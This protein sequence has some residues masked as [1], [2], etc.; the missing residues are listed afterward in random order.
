MAEVIFTDAVPV[1]SSGG[2]AAPAVYPPDSLPPVQ[3]TQPNPAKPKDSSLALGYEDFR[4]EV[5]GF[6]GWTR[7]IDNWDDAQKAELDDIVQSGVRQFYWPPSVEG[8]MV[9]WSFLSPH[10]TLSTSS[11][12]GYDLPDDFSGNLHSVI[13]H[14]TGGPLVPMN[15]GNLLSLV[16]GNSTQGAPAY[17]AVRPA[18]SD[19]SGLQKW[20]ILLY[21][22]PDGVYSLSYR[23][24]VGAQ[25]L[26]KTRP[27]PL[28]PVCHAE[29]VLESCLAVA[30]ERLNDESSL[31]RNRFKEL[32]AFSVAQDASMITEESVDNWPALA[33]TPTSLDLTY[34][35]LLR[36]VGQFLGYGW[37]SAKWTRDHNGVADDMVQAGL[38]QFYR[39]PLIEGQE[40]AHRWGFLRQNTTLSLVAGTA[41]YDLPAACS[42]RV[43]HFTYSA[44]AAEV[45]VVAVSDE[46]LRELIARNDASGPPQY[47]SFRAKASSGG[48]RQ[49]WQVLFY[50]KPNAA[51]TLS[52]EYEIVP[53]RLTYA[54]PFP[55][56]GVDHAETILASC[57]AAAEERLK[58]ESD[59]QRKRFL[60]R[61]GAS[62]QIDVA[63]APSDE[64]WPLGDPGEGSLDVSYGLLLKRVGHELG[65]GWDAGTWTVEERRRVDMVIHSGLR[66]FYT[67][68]PLPGEKHG[69][70][71]TFL[72]PVTTLATVASTYLYDLPADFAA[73]DGP[74]TFPPGATVLYRPI[75]IVNENYIRQR[76]MTDNFTRRPEVA[77]IRP[78]AHDGTQNTRYEIL[79][80]PTPDDA[81]TL[82]YRYRVNLLSLSD[83]RQF[84][85]GAQTH[86]EAILTSCLAA[87]EQMRDGK[88]GLH[89]E[90]FGVL[91]AA[92]VS[93]DR[94]GSCPER[95][96][97]PGE[98]DDPM[99]YWNYHDFQ[100]NIVTY[101]D[102]AY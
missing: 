98:M 86:A 56:G 71:W 40:A 31:H 73:M 81:Y 92:S 25:K 76:Q 38:R 16:T 11:G 28:G 72:R 95:L 101:N 66:Q 36:H 84:P 45:E 29:T 43:A 35:D 15:D 32:L 61:L 96:G 50:P 77:A 14:T 1:S 24:E 59:V 5:A 17:Y 58:P 51:F 34:G 13:N 93:A 8:K 39:P 91:L 67:P 78:K 55:L 100:D 63:K 12:Y 80:W 69:H 22:P 54:A 23:Y 75:E 21:P 33:A 62:I 68:P 44:D 60:A 89:T 90:R 3:P 64:T 94:R 10:A 30:E 87:A 52:Y 48:G 26:T 4:V 74:L 42:G 79:F 7:D 83:T 88:A 70:E 85:P 46:R 82:S 20:Q 9:R 37:D 47:F 6:L 65:M 19:G 18:P 27:Y 102:V 97:V 2:P 53:P 49:G 41:L 99:T 57:L